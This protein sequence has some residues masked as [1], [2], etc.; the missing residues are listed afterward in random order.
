MT[1]AA[2]RVPIEQANQFGVIETAADGQTI[3]A[4]HEKPDQATG[5]PDAPDQVY[6]SMG[7]Y[8]FSTD[9]LV[10]VVSQRRR[11]P[12]V[13]TRHGRQHHSDAGRL[14]RGARV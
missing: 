5:L 7:N 8:V 6:A 9:T 4:F 14:G 1:V 2:L 10:D 3:T 11:G 13:R 12:R